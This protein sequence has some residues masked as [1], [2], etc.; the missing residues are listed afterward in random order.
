MNISSHE[1]IELNSAII[2]AMRAANTSFLVLPDEEARVD[3]HINL[4]NTGEIEA[5]SFDQDRAL[6]ENIS[7]DAPRHGTLKIEYLYRDGNNC[8]QFESVSLSGTITR[9][10]A[11]VIYTALVCE[12]DDTFIPEKVGLEPLQGRWNDANF[13]IDGPDHPYHELEALSF[14]ESDQSIL[15]DDQ[16]EAFY[17]RCLDAVRDL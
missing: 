5:S 17:Q 4:T 2:P 8:K 1:I 10:R 16:I 3:I 9:F 13:D 12:D 14:V 6:L 15:S 11:S 7:D